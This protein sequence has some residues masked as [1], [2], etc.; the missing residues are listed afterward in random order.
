[1]KPCLENIRLS[2]LLSNTAF[3]VL[4]GML[5]NKGETFESVR[6]LENESLVLKKVDFPDNGL[7]S[8]IPSHILNEWSW[9]RTSDLYLS[10]EDPATKGCMM[11]MIRKNCVKNAFVRYNSN[12][13]MWEVS[14][15]GSTHA[16]ILGKGK[17][18]G[19]AL[20][21]AIIGWKTKD[22]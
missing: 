22:E 5:F 1:M 6:L 16:A 15:I 21:A 11:E 4:P 10:V 14:F 13:D 17:T 7:E 9:E 20:H 12:E 19:L 8:C 18:E 2:F 3:E